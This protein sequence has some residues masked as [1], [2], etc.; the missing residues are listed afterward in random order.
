[1]TKTRIHIIFSFTANCVRLL[2][3]KSI[4]LASPG[5]TDGGEN[6]VYPDLEGSVL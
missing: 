2:V 3:R 5:T 1:M 4:A 6:T